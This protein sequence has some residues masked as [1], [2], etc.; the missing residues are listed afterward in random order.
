MSLTPYTS[1]YTDVTTN[2]FDSDDLLDEFDRIAEFMAAWI[3]SYE[4]IGIGVIDFNSGENVTND[5]NVFPTSMINQRI[6]DASVT[7]VN[8][9]FPKRS[10]GDPYRIYTVLRFV[11]KDTTFT[12]SGPAGST[13]IFGVNREVYTPSQVEADGYY[14]ATI[15]TTY[16]ESGGVIIN[17]FADNTEAT[18][19]DGNDVLTM[20][21]K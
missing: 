1:T 8:I 7:T 5:V 19:V 6:I 11:D 3:A 18:A 2:I 13:H 4:S 17:V 16:S 12:V 14:A 21:A 20:G 9:N 15:M 10:D